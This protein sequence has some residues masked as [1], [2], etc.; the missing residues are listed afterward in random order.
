VTEYIFPDNQLCEYEV[1]VQC[2]I[3][4]LS[5]DCLQMFDCNCIL[6]QL[7]TQEELI[8]FI[9]MFST[10]HTSLYPEPD[11]LRYI[12]ILSFPSMPVYCE[13]SLPFT[14]AT[15]I[16]YSLLI[17]LMGATCPTHLISSY[18]VLLLNKPINTWGKLIFPI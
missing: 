14:L 15:K 12:L 3:K 1:T 5:Q 16:L 17:S 4:D 18:E 10:A 8:A 13:W 6:T 2:R 11:K 9:I 7:S